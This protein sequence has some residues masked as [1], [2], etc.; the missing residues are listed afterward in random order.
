M[1]RNADSQWMLHA[2]DLAS[3]AWGMTNPNP[4]VGAVLVRGGKIIG[5]GYHHKAGEP[6]AEVNAFLDAQS[7]GEDTRDAVLY[8]TLEPC[9]SYG[10]TP[11]CTER[12]LR[13]GVKKVVIG[14]LDPNPKHN[15]KAVAILEE[16]GIEVISGVEENA[17]RELN[18]AFFCWIT[19]GKPWVLLKMASTLDG[20]TAASSGDAFWVTGEAARER[21][22][23]LRRM[24]DAIMVGANTVRIDHPK[25][26]V[27]NPENWSRQPW[28]IVASSSMT[29]DE[30]FTYFPD[31]RA[32]VADPE[33]EGWENF[34]LRLG[35]RRMMMLLL[36]G[37]AELAAS[38]VSAGVVDSVEFHIAPKLLGGRNSHPV[39]G[40]TDPARMLDALPLKNIQVNRYGDDISVTGDLK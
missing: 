25:L 9:S 15:G 20:K 2:L 21:V 29:E 40:G 18:K 5:E 16:A 24:A 33:K 11:P 14:C 1:N 19:T 23:I 4:M 38:A 12:I 6:H 31:R 10:R 26:N 37:G 35:E 39:L 30:L 3:R 17:C 8:V 28:R 13:S 27:R 22:Q 36:E 7:R 32:E 34:L